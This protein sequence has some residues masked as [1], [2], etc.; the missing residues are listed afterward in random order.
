MV[1]LVEGLRVLAFCGAD[2]ASRLWF[3][4]VSVAFVLRKGEGERGSIATRPRSHCWRRRWPCGVCARAL[5]KRNAKCLPDMM[6]CVWTTG[7]YVAGCADKSTGQAQS[8]GIAALF[9]AGRG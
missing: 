6:C 3:W 8:T 4:G 1:E 5:G 9:V 2:G 7:N